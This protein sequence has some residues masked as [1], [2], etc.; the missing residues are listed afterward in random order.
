MLSD[1]CLAFSVA[2]AGNASALAPRTTGA[3]PRLRQR[4]V[5]GGDRLGARDAGDVGV[6]VTV[7]HRSPKRRLDTVL[8][9]WA[10]SDEHVTIA[11]VREAP[12]KAPRSSLVSLHSW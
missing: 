4:A 9:A 1:A 3:T 11:V 10:S 8:S 2:Y 6:F 7:E 12:P 5:D